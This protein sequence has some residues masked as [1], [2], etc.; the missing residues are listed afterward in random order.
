MQEFAE[1]RKVPGVPAGLL[2]DQVTGYPGLDDQIAIIMVL[3]WPTGQGSLTQLSLR[4]L[5]AIGCEGPCWFLFVLEEART[6][7]LSGVMLKMILLGWLWQTAG[8]GV[9]LPMYCL[10]NLCMRSESQIDQDIGN[11]NPRIIS[12]LQ[13]CFAVFF[14]L[15]FCVMALPAPQIVSYLFRQQMTIMGQL[16]YLYA[17]AAVGFLYF[18]Q[19]NAQPDERRVKYAVTAKLRGAYYF[20]FICSTIPHV[21]LILTSFAVTLLPFA[22]LEKYRGDLHLSQVFTLAFPWSAPPVESVEEGL[23]RF[24]QWDDFVGGACMLLWSIALYIRRC[25]QE[26]VHITYPAVWMEALASSVIFGPF[27]TAISFLRER[28]EVQLRALEESKEE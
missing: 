2:R 23:L 6:G 26:R 17:T 14:L 22:G 4:W 13:N 8:A 27:A 11:R 7:S 12:L 5:M 24:L 16:W 9:L 21:V 20:A 10:W 1:K 28:N 3:F 18:M 19:K 15:L 25:E